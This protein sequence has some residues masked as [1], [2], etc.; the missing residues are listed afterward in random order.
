MSFEWEDIFGDFD[1]L[2]TVAFNSEVSQKLSVM[3]LK[4]ISDI[5]SSSGDGRYDEY[6]LY[7]DVVKRKGDKPAKAK[8]STKKNLILCSK[9]FKFYVMLC[10]NALA[11]DAQQVLGYDGTTADNILDK[12]LNIKGDNP[13]LSPMLAQLFDTFYAKDAIKLAEYKDSMDYFSKK[14]GEAI[15]CEDAVILQKLTQIWVAFALTVARLLGN[16]LWQ[17]RA[18]LTFKHAA[19]ALRNCYLMTQTPADESLFNFIEETVLDNC[20]VKPKSTKSAKSAKGKKGAKG[21]KGAKTS[22]K[23]ADEK[24]ST[25]KAKKVE[26]P[27]PE[28]DA[29]E[30]AEAEG[31]DAEDAEDGDGEEVEVEDEE[32]AADAEPEEAETKKSAKSKPK[33][34]AP[35]AEKKKTKSK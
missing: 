25:K 31:E 10:F 8:T 3:I 4:H 9:S 29:E 16:Q 26:E 18:S 7:D 14:L 21:A 23:D 20:P 24:K 12:L 34:D 13:K 27:E 17:S 15:S 5:A 19:S 2:T 35:S 33:K 22:K 32:E 28:E 30:D 1:G 11:A 6:K